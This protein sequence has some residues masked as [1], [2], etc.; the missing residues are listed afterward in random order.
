MSF[1]LEIKVPKSWWDE[2]SV[3]REIEKTL[4][5]VTG[6][7]IQKD[8]KTTTKGWKRENRP[9]FPVIFRENNREMAV[10]V[11][12]TDTPY[13]FVNDGTDPRLIVPRGGNPL[14]RFKPG[15][16]AATS[17]G[18]IKSRRPTRYGAVIEVPYV[19]HP[20]IAAR[21]FDDTISKRQRATFGIDIAAAIYR[22]MTN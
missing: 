19:R 3:K 18:S 14:L 2:K 7:K 22:G 9:K 6:K 21:G 15:Y 17:K 10:K 12:T 11:A 5:K 20:G 16:R 4:K 8:F 1:A 13:V